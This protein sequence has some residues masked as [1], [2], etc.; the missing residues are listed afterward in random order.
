[1]DLITRIKQAWN[2]FIDDDTSS[3]NNYTNYG[4]SYSYHQDRI[5][6]SPRNDKSIV[7]AVYNRI[8]LDCAQYVLHHVML[9]K[10]KRYQKDMDT[11]LNICLQLSANKDQTARAFIQDVV[12]AIF[13]AGCIA[14]VPIDTTGDPKLSGSW[15]IKSLRVGKIT[16]WYPDNIRVEVYNDRKGIRQEIVVAKENCAIIENPFFAIMNEPN[17]TARRLIYK[18]DLLDAIDKQ[19]GS[20]KLDLIIQLPYAI[21]SDSRLA[22]AKQR[23]DDIEAQLTGSKYGIAYTDG[24]EHVTQL[25]RPVENNLLTQIQYLTS[26][27]FSQLGFVI[28]ILDGTADANTMN[29]YRNHTIDPIMN[30]LI[31]EF[32]R[33]F[34]TKTAITEGQTIMCFS[35]PLRSVPVSMLADVADKLS[36]NEIVTANELRSSMGLPPSDDPNAD[37]LKNKN[38]PNSNPNPVVPTNSNDL[39]NQSTVKPPPTGV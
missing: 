12:M 14:V 13:N 38:M 17:S 4:A 15:D 30:A 35:D 9:D 11:D 19:S 28:G 39:A 25:N 34:L 37:K 29:N 7:N 21:R 32:K 22:Q 23:R 5:S 6:V 36:R 8:A 3:L 27:L 18:L 1:M 24:T 2:A 26:M 20:G 16:Q 33:K 10:N 31:D